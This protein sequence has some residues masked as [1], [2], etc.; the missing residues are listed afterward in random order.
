M[1]I[2]LFVD[3]EKYAKKSYRVMHGYSLPPVGAKVKIEYMAGL[4]WYMIW[5]DCPDEENLIFGWITQKKEV[6]RI[7]RELNYIIQ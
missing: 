4:N 7:A 3:I 1:Q 6:Q 2:S 5:I